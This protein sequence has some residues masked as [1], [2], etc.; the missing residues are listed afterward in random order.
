M[1]LVLLWCLGVI[2]DKGF[3]MDSFCIPIHTTYYNTILLYLLLTLQGMNGDDIK[4]AQCSFSPHLT[5]SNDEIALGN[6]ASAFFF[7]T[8]FLLSNYL[9]SSL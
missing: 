4:Q 9:L 2:T 5:S 8:A 7:V 3:Q 6:S 1:L